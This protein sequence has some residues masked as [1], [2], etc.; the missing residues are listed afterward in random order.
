MKQTAIQVDI[1]NL[2]DMLC[3]SQNLMVNG[4]L[5]YFRMAVS[6]GESPIFRHAK[7][8]PSHGCS[9]DQKCDANTGYI[10]HDLNK[11]DLDEPEIGV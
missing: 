10:V 8:P 4:H 5:P 7:G 2:K 9:L 11:K 1:L 3:L 6:C